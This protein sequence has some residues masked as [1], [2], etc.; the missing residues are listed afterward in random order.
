MMMMMRTIRD[1]TMLFI[2]LMNF[3]GDGDDVNDDGDDHYDYNDDDR[4]DGGGDDY[5]LRV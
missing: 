2:N 3:C 5:W 4:D 1:T